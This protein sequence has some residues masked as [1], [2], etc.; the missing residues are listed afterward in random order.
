MNEEPHAKVTLTQILEKVESVQD[1]VQD[2]RLQ[3]KEHNHIKNDIEDLSNLCKNLRKRI[4]EH[5]QYICRQTGR[6]AG[7][8]SVFEIA[9]H[10]APVILAIAGMLLGHYA[11]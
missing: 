4:D 10:W 3:I 6:Y 9:R 2:L 7:M 8:S 11:I 5:D 1:D